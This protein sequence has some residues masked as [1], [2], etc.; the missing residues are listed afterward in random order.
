MV[1]MLFTCCTA[2]ATPRAEMPGAPW[3]VALQRLVC[4]RDRLDPF[5]VRGAHVYLK[6]VVGGTLAG[7]SEAARL[8]A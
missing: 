8:K 5:R 4:F 6:R 1:Y 2:R 3:S 7:A